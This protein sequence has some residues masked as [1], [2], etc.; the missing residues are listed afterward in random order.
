VEHG[1]EPDAGAE[2][3]GVGRDGDQGL[4]G[5]FEQQVIDDRLVVIGDVG[6]R[7]RQGEDNMEIG[8]GQQFNLA[9]GQPL[10]GSGGLALRAMPVAAGIVRDAQVG[11][12]LAAFDMPA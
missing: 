7:S 11:A 1:G 3:L 9:V 6:D 8:H 12:L 2:V 10:L 5:G 4:G